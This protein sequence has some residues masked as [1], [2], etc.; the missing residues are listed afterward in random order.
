M[1]AEVF[2]VV[3]AAGDYTAGISEEA[4]FDR[5]REDVE[6][7]A[8]CPI[9]LVRVI[10][11]IDVPVPITL[12]GAASVRYGGAMLREVTAQDVEDAR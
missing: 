3:D 10:V 1:E 5:Y 9:R 11:D 2:I 4:A 12:R 6:E 7:Q 8:K